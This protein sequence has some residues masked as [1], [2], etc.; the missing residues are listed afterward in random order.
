MTNYLA[1]YLLRFLKFYSMKNV[2]IISVLCIISS[3]IYGENKELRILEYEKVIEDLKVNGEKSV[4]FKNLDCFSL[5]YLDFGC[6]D[7]LK[8]LKPEYFKTYHVD[9]SELIVNFKRD[10]VL[11]RK[12]EYS[13]V[14]DLLNDY[15]KLEELCK[16]ILGVDSKLP[17]NISSPIYIKDEKYA[18]LDIYGYFWSNSYKLLLIDGVLKVE[19]IHM[20]TE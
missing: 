15:K 18:V 19:L 8:K 5:L 13:K 3:V 2:L 14:S 1:K 16:E 20:I 10:I 11:T 4:Y 6:Y 7:F 17:Y 9:T 12:E